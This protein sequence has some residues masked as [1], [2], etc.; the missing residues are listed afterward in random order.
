VVAERGMSKLLAHPACRSNNV[1]RGP[2]CGSIAH[3]VRP[4]TFRLR[5]YDPKLTSFRQVSY[6]PARLTWCLGLLVF[7]KENAVCRDT[8]ATAWDGRDHTSLPF[9]SGGSIAI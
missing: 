7:G 1:R 9:Y 3:L 6:P 5:P 4:S 2:D 8:A